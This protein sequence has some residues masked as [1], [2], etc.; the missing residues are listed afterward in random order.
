MQF[1]RIE[2]GEL[3]EMSREHSRK[4]QLSDICESDINSLDDH[5]LF[6]V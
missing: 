6:F 1:L 4:K 3:I 2:N 5:L